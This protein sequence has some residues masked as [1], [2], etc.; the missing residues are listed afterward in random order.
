MNYVSLPDGLDEIFP[1][2][3]IHNYGWRVFSLVLVIK[4]VRNFPEGVLS[5][6]MCRYHTLTRYRRIIKKCDLI[7]Y[8]PSSPLAW[9]ARC[10]TRNMTSKQVLAFYAQVKQN[11]YRSRKIL[12]YELR[13]WISRKMLCLVSWYESIS[14]KVGY[15]N[16]P[17]SPGHSGTNFVGYS[18]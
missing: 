17:Y 1:N 18:V 3:T 7:V 10:Q 12:S 4:P 8:F 2:T 13:S 15:T 6:V 11:Q 14:R 5:C 9:G 16:D